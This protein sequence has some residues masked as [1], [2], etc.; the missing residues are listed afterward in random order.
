MKKSSILY[1]FFLF[2]PIAI[3][4]RLVNADITMQF[5][6]AAAAAFLHWQRWLVILLKIS[7]CIM[8]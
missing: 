5:I 3:V 7:R 2:I 8:A 1:I 4:L 6:A